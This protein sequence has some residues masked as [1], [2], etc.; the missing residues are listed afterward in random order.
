[1]PCSL[2]QNAEAFILKHLGIFYSA[3]SF[4]YPFFSKILLPLNNASSCR[5]T[6]SY[7]D[8][9]TDSSTF[10]NGYAPRNSGIGIDNHII[11]QDRMT[12]DS[13]YRVPPAHPAGNSL[14]PRLP[15][16]YSFTLFP[17]MQVAPITT[18][19]PWSMVK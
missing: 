3:E 15:P 10:S 4:F 7:P 9:T 13:L 8:I 19:V 14:L 2:T 17:I 12:G 1:M 16:E 5:N 6:L 18:P 11:F